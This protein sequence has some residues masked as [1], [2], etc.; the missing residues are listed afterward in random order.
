MVQ[1]RAVWYYPL[2]YSFKQEVKLIN[3]KII[4]IFL[5]FDILAGYLIYFIY[6]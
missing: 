3:S 5:Q 6:N 4:F 2:R 1:H